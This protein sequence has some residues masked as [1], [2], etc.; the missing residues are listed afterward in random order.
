MCLLNRCFA[1]RHF[2]EQVRRVERLPSGRGPSHHSQIRSSLTA[3]QAKRRGGRQKRQS[4]PPPK[5][6]GARK[7][8][9]IAAVVGTVVLTSLASTHG[10]PVY[11]NAEEATTGPR[12]HKTPAE[13]RALYMSELRANSDRGETLADFQ[14]EL[15]A[16]VWV[17][18]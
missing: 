15:N 13:A 3:G 2:F 5:R 4:P 11:L 9:E 17:G 8:N 6:R 18:C 10:L 12:K 1:C 16:G 14:S 7:R